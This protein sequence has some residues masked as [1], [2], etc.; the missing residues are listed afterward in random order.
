METTNELLQQ[1]NTMQTNHIK[2]LEERIEVI[3]KHKQHLNETI[4]RQAHQLE[5][6]FKKIEFINKTNDDLIVHLEV[7]REQKKIDND[8][9]GK[10]FAAA[11]KDKEVIKQFKQLINQQGKQIID[12]QKENNSLFY[13]SCTNNTTLAL[14]KEVKEAVKEAVKD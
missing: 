5:S 14:Q 10:L 6:Q 7:I 13:E 2:L 9:I 4:S 1:L 11:K 3:N 8:T 12:L